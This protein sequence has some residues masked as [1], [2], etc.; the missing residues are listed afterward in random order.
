MRLLVGLHCIESKISWLQTTKSLF[1]VC[2]NGWLMC[3]DVLV[4]QVTG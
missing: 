2:L 1:H 3:E 4:F